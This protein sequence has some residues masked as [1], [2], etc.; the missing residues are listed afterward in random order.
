MS[1]QGAGVTVVVGTAVVVGAGAPVTSGVTTTLPSIGAP[2]TPTTGAWPSTGGATGTTGAGTPGTGSPATNGATVVGKTVVG[3]GDAEAEDGA[4]MVVVSDSTAR[5]AWC[6][7]SV[8]SI[9]LPAS[10]SFARPL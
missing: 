7:T 8:D 9:G 4:A 2:S 10:A 6:C 5:R 3:V 1:D